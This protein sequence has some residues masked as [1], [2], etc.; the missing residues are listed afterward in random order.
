MPQIRASF[1]AV[2]LTRAL[3]AMK[4]AEYKGVVTVS[5]DG[6]I[7]ILPIDHAAVSKADEPRP[8]FSM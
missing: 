2:D 3:K 6:S 5:R 1:K 8:K 4:A 7:T